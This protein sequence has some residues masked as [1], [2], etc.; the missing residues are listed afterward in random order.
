MEAKGGAAGEMRR[1]HIIYF[2]NRMGRVE[3]PH[4]FRVHHLSRNGVHLRDVKRWLS[5]LRGKDMPDSFAWSYKRKYKT[6]Y[7]WQDLVDDDLITPIA[8]DEYVLKGSEIPII[9]SVTG[10]CS[11]CR[12][13]KSSMQKPVK[14]KEDA[15]IKAATAAVEIEENESGTSDSET[16][17]TTVDS[18]ESNPGFMPDGKQESKENPGKMLSSGL[19]RKN[20]K[21]DAD[22]EK[23][24]DAGSAAAPSTRSS[25]LRS[26]S[27]SS[28]ASHVFRNLI[29]C[30]AVET[31]DSALVKR[32]Y[33]ASRNPSGEAEEICKVEKLGGSDRIFGFAWNHQQH[34]TKKCWKGEKNAKRAT[35]DSINQ[36][37]VSAAYKTVAEPNCSQCGKA[38]KPE[39]MH[40]HMKS[41]KGMKKQSKSA[42]SAAEKKTSSSQQ[43]SATDPPFKEE[44]SYFLMTH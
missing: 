27:H 6:G 33:G 44:P 37:T 36:K 35:S 32:V 40:T 8:D 22:A 19:L 14:E 38:F 16:S 15:K 4:L 43:G 2:L 42:N 39:K 1:V 20:R 41:C 7:V 31:N 28:G 3:H 26:K 10:T 18:I 9:P 11:S 23:N 5:D 21:K 30:G 25:F 29:T 34:K 12:E 17:A 24:K 13:K